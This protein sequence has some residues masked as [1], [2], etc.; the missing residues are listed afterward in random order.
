VS[1]FYSPKS[2]PANPKRA[3]ESRLYHQELGN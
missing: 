3:C 2:M 1:I